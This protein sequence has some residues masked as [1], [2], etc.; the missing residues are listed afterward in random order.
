MYKRHGLNVYKRHGLVYKSLKLVDGQLILAWQYFKS[1]GM[2]A[3][4]IVQIKL[5]KF[6]GVFTPQMWVWRKVNKNN[7]KWKLLI[8]SQFRNREKSYWNWYIG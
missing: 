6:K 5:Y 3:N 7:T 1:G 8:T 2:G 4:C